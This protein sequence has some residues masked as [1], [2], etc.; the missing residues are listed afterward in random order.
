[1]QTES[2]LGEETNMEP[3][4]LRRAMDL[5]GRA[6]KY[7][8]P[9]NTAFLT[10]AEQAALKCL[11][12]GE[13]QITMELYGGGTDCDRKCAF[14]LPSWQEALDEP[15]AIGAVRITVA[16]GT[17]GHRDYL[18]SLLAL[19]VKRESLGDLRLV[20]GGAYLYCLHSIQDYIC[21][22]LEKIGRCGVKATPAALEEVPPLV[23]EYQ[24]VTFTVQS[25]RLD[26]IC[27]GIFGLS[28]TA[29]QGRILQ[30]SVFVNDTPCLKP[31]TTLHPG[32]VI[33]LRGSGKATLR[34]PG[35]T[36]RKGRIFIHA[37]LW[38]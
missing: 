33:T 5:A 3:D 22:N 18:G 31:D 25:P 35:G 14:F 9:T 21:Q 10:P 38:K 30:G 19:G 12:R 6:E 8:A 16:F 23:R 1:M 32:D 15:E 26:S 24:P 13:P 28:R 29:A 4:L 11:V 34:P 2:S 27:G 37:D 20:E 36:S 17:P 7:A